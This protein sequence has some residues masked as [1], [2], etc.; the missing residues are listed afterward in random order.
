MKQ[1]YNKICWRIGQE[2]TPDTFIQADNYISSQHNLIRR[3]IAGKYYGLLP[4]PG[5]TGAPSLTVRANVNNRDFYLENL[6]CFGTTEMGYLISFENYPIGVASSSSLGVASRYAASP[7]PPGVASRYAPLPAKLSIPDSAA[8][9]FYVVLR[10]NPYQQV[11]IEP[12]DND[13]APEAHAEYQLAIRE[14]NQIAAD[15][16]A[17]VKIDNSHYS[18][19]ID[20]DYIPPCMSVNACSNLLEVFESFQTLFTEIQSI[21]EHKKDQFGKMMYPL[22]LLHHELEGFS[23]GEPPIALVRLI[24][25]FMATYRFFIPEVRKIAHPD[26]LGEYCHDDVA[27]IFKSLLSSLHEVKMMVG[28]VEIVEEEDFTPKI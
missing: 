4:P 15:E 21:I 3:L 12:V 8:S 17:I 13:E 6:S 25:K 27:I 16:L 14:L 11:L 5:E 24:K 19:A 26:A 10:I 18:P 23:S 20:N 22:I 9:A 1:K 2:I 7:D 28:K